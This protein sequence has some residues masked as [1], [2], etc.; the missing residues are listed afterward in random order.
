MG[1]NILSDKLDQI[2]KGDLGIHFDD[3]FLWGELDAQLGN[4][5][6]VL[7]E[8]RLLMAACITLLI[9]LFPIVL[10]MDSKPVQL[11]MENQSIPQVLAEAEV[12]D[13]IPAL[14]EKKKVIQTSIL[15]VHRKEIIVSPIA[16]MDF[17]RIEMNRIQKLKEKK[18]ER[19]LF[20]DQDISIIQASLGTPSIE[21][22]KSLK[23]RAQLQAFSQPVQLNNQAFK[24]KLFESSNK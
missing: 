10:R 1:H 20:A 18:I 19:Q 15:F 24:I 12:L 7:I 6:A 8:R 13:L 16:S 21:K 23:V 22:G 11:T 5:K 17:S 14:E 3:A 2:Q 9:L 4:N